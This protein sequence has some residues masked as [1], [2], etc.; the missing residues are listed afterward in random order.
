M[1]VC[2]CVWGPIKISCSTFQRANNNDADQAGLMHRLVC[3]YS[4][5][6]KPDFPATNHT[7]YMC[8]NWILRPSS[9]STQSHHF[10]FYELKTHIKLLP[11]A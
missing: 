2:V 1:C 5:A 11:R 9:I 4:Q 6:T 8:G 3:T 10:I 7:I